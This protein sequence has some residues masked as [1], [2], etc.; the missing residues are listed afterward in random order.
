MVPDYKMDR[1]KTPMKAVVYEKYGPPEFLQIRE[2]EKPVPGD[3]EVLIRVRAATVPAEALLLRSLPFS[4]FLWLLTRIG[5]G[6]TKPRKTIM[7][8]ELSGEIA[9][10]GKD[11][12][13]F[14]EGDQVFGSDLSGLGTYAEYKCMPENKVL[15]IEIQWT[16]K[17]A[18]WMLCRIFVTIL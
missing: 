12:K 16:G 17:V 3:H 13:R 6:L 4:P 9:S 18:R 15:A 7:G 1:G 10:V 2:M 14:K 5:I 11:V 8:S